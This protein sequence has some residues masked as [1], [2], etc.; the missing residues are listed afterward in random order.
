MMRRILKLKNKSSSLFHRLL[1]SF[2]LIIV[3]LA[4]FNYLSFTYFR[5]QIR[6][7]IIRYNTQNLNNTTDGFE[8][9]FSLVIKLMYSFYSKDRVQLLNK[10]DFSYEIANQLRTDILNTVSNDL[11]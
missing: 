11:L 2:L 7:E 9:H 8:N 1:L 10:P 4:S 3:L 5:K 6:E